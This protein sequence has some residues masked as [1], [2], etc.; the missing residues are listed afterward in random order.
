MTSVDAAWRPGGS[1]V[2][3]RVLVEAIASN[4]AV[5]MSVAVART[6]KPHTPNAEL[7]DTNHGSTGEIASS[8]CQ[9]DNRVVRSATGDSGI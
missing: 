1:D 9:V 5:A 2:I 8:N 3:S 6:F 4:T 7:I